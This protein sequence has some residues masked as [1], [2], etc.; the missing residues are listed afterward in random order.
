MSVTRQS[1]DALA[2]RIAAVAPEIRDKLVP[3]LIQS[4]EEV[5]RKA[6]ALAEASRRTGDLIESITATPPGQT[7]PAYAQGGASIT[8]HGLQ[9]VVTAGD[10]D[11]RHG[12]LVEF[13]TEARHHAHGTSTGTMP[14]QPFLLP[15]WRLSKTRV[16]RRL[17]RAV[18]AGV[19]AAVAAGNGGGNDG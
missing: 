16:E 15:S 10:Q 18:N 5:A 19:K 3:A 9:A 2:K 6:R 8:T 4:A 1:S 12:H 11:N 14:A 17:Q 7:T 13:G